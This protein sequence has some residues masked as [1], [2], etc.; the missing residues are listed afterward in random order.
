M[1]LEYFLLYNIN[2]EI[3]FLGGACIQDMFTSGAH[4]GRLHPCSR[5]F[6]GLIPSVPSKLF[7][8]TLVVRMMGEGFLLL[9]SCCDIYQVTPGLYRGIKGS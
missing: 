2:S 1:R 3:T 4:G 8:Q 7:A 5:R 6:H 9:S